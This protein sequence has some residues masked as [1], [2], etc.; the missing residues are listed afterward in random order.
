MSEKMKRHVAYLL[1]QHCPDS[2][3]LELFER[4]QG[5][6]IEDADSWASVSQESEVNE[7]VNALRKAS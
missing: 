2:K 3:I 1:R 6:A 5:C 4:S 7:R